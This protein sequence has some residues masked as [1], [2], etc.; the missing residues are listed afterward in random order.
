MHQKRKKAFYVLK[1]LERPYAFL[2]EFIY[3]PASDVIII[4]EKDY[5]VFTY[6]IDP[7]MKNRI[8]Y[9]K[10]PYFLGKVKRTADTAQ[11]ARDIC[12]NLNSRKPDDEDRDLNG[13][14]DNP[15]DLE[16][17]GKKRKAKT[18]RTKNEKKTKLTESRKSKDTERALD[19]NDMLTPEFMQNLTKEL[20]SYEK[21][22]EELDEA[23]KVIHQK[24][25]LLKEF[26]DK[27]KSYNDE[28]NAVDDKYQKLIEIIKKKEKQIIELKLQLKGQKGTKVANAEKNSDT[29]WTLRY[30]E[31]ADDLFGLLDDSSVYV[32]GVASCYIIRAAKTRTDLARM[33]LHEIFTEKALKTC[34]FYSLDEHAINTLVEVVGYIDRASGGDFDYVSKENII[35]S[36]KNRLYYLNKIQP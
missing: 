24:S 6:P 26:I 32:N 27:L 8:F 13:P 33:L 17:N 22:Q 29:R 15:A 5:T 1:F 10:W 30:P 23:E 19:D 11:T 18:E 2:D 20:E 36:I 34:D 31:E 14:E 4:N 21:Q 7:C 25:C 16:K 3:I 12:R 28:E 35:R 9:D